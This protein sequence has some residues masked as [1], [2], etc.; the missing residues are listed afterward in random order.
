MS[1]IYRV[2]ERELDTP[3]VASDARTQEQNR[4]L[5]ACRVGGGTP[6]R[7]G[8]TG[9][10]RAGGGFRQR[11]ARRRR[12]AA[13]VRKGHARRRPRVAACRGEEHAGCPLRGLRGRSTDTWPPRTHRRD[14][15][16]PRGRATGGGGEQNERTEYAETAHLLHT[17][18]T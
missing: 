2:R 6:I 16:V 1:G 5:P 4:F 8:G 3:E 15:G 11:D 14:A 18:W 7:R 10:R 17:P 12:L 9:R 13:K